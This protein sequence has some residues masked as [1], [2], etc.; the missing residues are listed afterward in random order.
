MHCNA[1]GAIINEGADTCPNCGEAVSETI[2]SLENAPTDRTLTYGEAPTSYETTKLE[3]ESDAA[4]VACAVH[5]YAVATGNCDACGKPCCDRCLVLDGERKHCQ[6]CAGA[7]ESSEAQ[8]AEQIEPQHT[9]PASQPTTAHVSSSPKKSGV[10][11]GLIIVG[12][13]VVALIGAGVWAYLKFSGPTPVKLTARDMELLLNEVMAPNQLQMLSNN[14]EQKKELT[15]QIKRILALAYEGE[16]LGLEKRPK[17]ESEIKF[18]EDQALGAAYQKKNP[19]VQPSDEEVTAHLQAHPKEFDEFL[20]ANPQFKGKMAGPDEERRKGFAKFKVVTERARK[21]GLDKE[22]ATKLIILLQRS[23]VLANAYV[24]EL[25]KPE[26]EQYYNEHKEELDQVHARHILISIQSP[27]NKEEARKQAQ[28][29]LD[30]VRS[31]EDFVS[32]AKEYSHDGSKD[33]GG[34]LGFFTRGAMV[35]E[36][37]TAAFSLKPGEVS[38]LVET[39]FGFHIIKVE[40]H[41]EPSLDDTVFQQ[42]ILTKLDRAQ[43]EKKIDD[44]AAASKV[45]VPEDFNITVQPTVPPAFTPGGERPF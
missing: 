21:D 17:V 7:L 40:E 42:Q 24:V 1:C 12:L 10:G 36:F 11:V 37:E 38:D 22:E 30:R 35:P 43:L 4:P 45:E 41:R 16:K 27:E 25:Q 13:L 32:L 5:D 9:A 20:E 31:G 15:K 3:T 26:I 19:S 33:E 29:I 28:S 44:I 39:Q 14:P 8:T 6:E 34:D 2:A 18:R 23:Q